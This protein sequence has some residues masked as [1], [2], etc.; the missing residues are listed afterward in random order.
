[1]QILSAKYRDPKKGKYPAKPKK[2]V[3]INAFIQKKAVT[4][5]DTCLFT[6]ILSKVIIRFYASNKKH[7]N[8]KC[9]FVDLKLP[10]FRSSELHYF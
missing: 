7:G 4:S 2:S 9:S 8:N 3:K 1:M 10:V 5:L 6:F